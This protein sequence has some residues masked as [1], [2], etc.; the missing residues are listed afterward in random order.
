MLQTASKLYMVVNNAPPQFFPHPPDSI[1]TITIILTHNFFDRLTMN[2]V[3]TA[4]ANVT[5]ESHRTADML[6][7]SQGHL[8][9][10]VNMFF[11]ILNSPTQKGITLLPIFYTWEGCKRKPDYYIKKNTAAV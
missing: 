1:E 2:W 7:L 11:L 8:S 6:L 9:R 5:C 3:S 10:I 4:F